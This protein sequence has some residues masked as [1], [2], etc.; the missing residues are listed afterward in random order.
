M[1]T[2][3]FISNITYKITSFSSPSIHA[4]QKMGM[5]FVHAANWSEISVEQRAGLEKDHNIIIYNVPINR[6]PFSLSNIT[7]Y[8]QLCH[9]VKDNQVDFIHCNTPVGGLLGRLVG[10]KCK[11][12]KVLYQAHGFHFYKGAPIRNWMIY[13][14]VEKWL[15]HYTDCIVTMNAED[16]LI[17]KRFR[18]RKAG[19]IY[20]VHGVGID[21]REYKGLDLY[22]WDKRKEM[23]FVEDDI[24]LISM[25]DLIPRKNYTVAIEAIS[26]CKDPRIQYIICGKGPDLEK[27]EE[28][29]KKLGV[30]KQVHF[31]GFRSDVK[32][33]LAAADIFILTS[34][35]EGLPRSVMEAMAAGLPC[36]VSKIRGNVDLVQNGQGGFLCDPGRSEEFTEAIKKCDSNTRKRM[37]SNNLESV[38]QV[39]IHIIENEI[40]NI[41]KSVFV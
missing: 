4:A 39:D 33:L 32:E 28:Q 9:I 31:L 37:K 17:A 10:K 26:K 34:L 14:P 18:L 1:N 24:V 8:K 23:G 13:Y 5:R 30:E 6:S 11:V 2:I 38:K 21:L 3:L 19:R 41:Y 35:Q 7:A 29:A 22:R 15:A 27:L 36:I 20:N 12:K 16:N 25:G 40:E